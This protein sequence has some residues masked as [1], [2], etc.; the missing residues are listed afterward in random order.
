MGYQS[1]ADGGSAITEYIVE[2]SA[3]PDFRD[4]AT[5]GG[6][7]HYSVAAA[8]SQAGPFV[9]TLSPANG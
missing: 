4:T 5:D 1:Q 7:F 2:W 8:A 6:V 9:M 3:Q